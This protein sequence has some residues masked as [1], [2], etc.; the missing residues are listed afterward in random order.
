VAQYVKGTFVRDAV[1][2]G[3]ITTLI[4]PATSLKGYESLRQAKRRL[5]Q[6]GV[7]LTDAQLA[8]RI[9]STFAR[10][11]GEGKV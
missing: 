3:V 5:E 7:E 4:V 10:L 9:A 8:N 2:V 1:N 11:K 6:A